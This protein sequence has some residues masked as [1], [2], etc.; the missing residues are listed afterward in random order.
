MED[1]ITVT[2]SLGYRYLWIDQHCIDQSDPV[3][4]QYQI[5]NMDKIY[6]NSDL[7][8]IAAAGEIHSG[9]CLELVRDQNLNNSLSILRIL[10][11]TKH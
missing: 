11:Y 1:A 10:H 2:Q 4:K 6:A 9:D 5:A 7:T 3:Q 8:I